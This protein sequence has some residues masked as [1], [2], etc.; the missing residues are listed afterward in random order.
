MAGKQKYSN[1]NP[2]KETPEKFDRPAGVGGSDGSGKYPNYWSYKSRSGHSL[3][4]DDSKGHETVS[5][6]HRSGSAIQMMPDGALHI[7]AHNS[8]YTATFGEDR[9]VISGAHDIVVKGDA[10]LRVYGDY[11][12]TCHKDYNLTVNGNFNMIAK[13]HNRHVRGNI[14][15]KA[16]SENKKLEGSSTMTTQGAIA[17]TAKGSVSVGSLDQLHLG[18]SK[19]MNMQV[20]QGDITSNIEQGNFHFESKSGTFEAKM[21]DAIKFLSDSG[22]I[23]MIAQETAKILSKQGNVNISAQSGDVA[24]T[25]E[26]G[27]AQMRG[28]T[29]GISGTSEAHVSGATVHVKGSGVTNVDG[30]KVNLAGGLAQLMPDLP[31]SDI[32]SA[33]GKLGVAK[34]VTQPME[35]MSED[36]GWF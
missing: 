12:V 30:P 26:S 27:K 35:E 24:V 11:N 20:G 31:I 2:G 8:K 17:H 23:H 25:A 9:L 18:G 32:M 6:Q 21:K 29:A 4:F 34:A 10:S 16:K 1:N 36:P 14:D 33:V 19:G 28:Q 7:T 15:T 5:L 3:V 22:A 13:N